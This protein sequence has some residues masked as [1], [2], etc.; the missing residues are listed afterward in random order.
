MQWR[1]SIRPLDKI[2]DVKE[3]VM[4]PCKIPPEFVEEY[5]LPE[6]AKR[7]RIVYMGD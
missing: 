7:M 2:H 4:C 6:D 5:C 3:E 1:K